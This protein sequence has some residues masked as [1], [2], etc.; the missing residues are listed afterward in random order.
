MLRFLIK[1]SSPKAGMVRQ[2]K[3]CYCTL[4]P[5]FLVWWLAIWCRPNNPCPQAGGNQV[6]SQVLRTQNKVKGESH[7][8]F[9]FNWWSITK[10]VQTD[11]SPVRAINS[12]VCETIWNNRLIRAMPAFYPMVLSSLWKM[13]Q[14]I[15]TKKNIAH[16]QEG[17][18]QLKQ[19]VHKQNAQR[20]LTF[21]WYFQK[22]PKS[23]L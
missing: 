12:P 8:A 15:E 10:F 4:H 11:F 5:R 1:T 19:R 3:F 16:L 9:F 7:L 13:A 20:S 22:S 23:Q 14:K 18:T 21:C 17:K 6:T 2:R